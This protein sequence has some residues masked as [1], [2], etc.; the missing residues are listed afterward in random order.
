[1]CNL[2]TDKIKSITKKTIMFLVNR[3]LISEKLAS[4]LIETLGLKHA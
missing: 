3:G 2:F 4:L 1:M